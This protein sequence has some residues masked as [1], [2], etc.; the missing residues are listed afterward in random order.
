MFNLK[1]QKQKKRNTTNLN[2]PKPFFGVEVYIL[3]MHKVNLF[4][5]PT[6]GPNI[7]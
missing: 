5:F 4:I 6:Q 3:L 1:K 2:L 7:P